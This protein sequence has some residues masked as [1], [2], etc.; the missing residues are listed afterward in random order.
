M[1]VRGITRRV[2]DLGRIVLPRQVR[3]IA[4]IR[5]G[6][7]MEIF[8]SQDGITLKKYYPET[9]L[10]ELVRRLDEVIEDSCIELGSERIGYIRK[11]IRD[12]QLLLEPQV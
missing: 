4:G 8:V 1:K 6:T 3:E 11:T 2:D 7:T 9:D 12:I 10:A 5:E